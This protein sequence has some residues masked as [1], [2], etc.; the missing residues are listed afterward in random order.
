MEKNKIIWVIFSVA[1]LALVVVLGIIL[2][3]PKDE[4]LASSVSG[5]GSEAT[6]SF[7]PIQWVRTS[8]EPPGLQPKEKPAEPEEFVVVLGESVPEE[9]PSIVVE[10]PVTPPAKLQPEPV[11][12]AES[13]KREPVVTAPPE[14]PVKV[15]I[16]Q[17]QPKP[18]VKTVSSTEY[19]IQAGSFTS[20][21]R[22][23]QVKDTLSAKGVVSRI[24][25][26]EL[27]GELYFRVRIGPYQNK[28]EAEKFL[29]WI[30]E[31]QNFEGSY[32]SE[33]KVDRLVQN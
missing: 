8:Q 15:Q 29:T 33:V 2:L 10:T 22:A 18:S 14:T 1:F 3:L 13:L 17:T 25:S 23:E 11:K 26:R 27:E 24:V 20:K 31:I 21:T 5:S 6:S 30:K 9:T 32:I 4:A 7:D 12:P 19:W 16:P 28:Q